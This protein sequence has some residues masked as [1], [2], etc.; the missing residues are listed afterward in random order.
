MTIETNSFMADENFC[1]AHNWALPREY[2][3]ITVAD[4]GAGIPAEDVQH[5][6]EPFFT[7]KKAGE[8]TGLGL[9]V[10]YG[11][12]QQHQGQILVSSEE[13]VGTIFKVY[14]PASDGQNESPE[15]EEIEFL[16]GGKE[17]ILVAEDEPEVLDLIVSMLEE[18]GYTVITARDGVEACAVFDDNVQTIDLAL[19][20]VIMPKMQGKA[21]YDHIREIDGS[22]PVVF[23]TGYTAR[24]I[25]SQY[26]AENDLALLQKPYS[27]QALFRTIKEALAARTS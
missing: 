21:V 23:S 14:L 2:M 1:A 27:P 26:L 15:S 20:D 3:V 25:D 9:S 16:A 7:T 8:G 6:F 10:A 4:T 19:L 24:E 12:V 18:M 22:L 17:T 13:G 11:I 5:I